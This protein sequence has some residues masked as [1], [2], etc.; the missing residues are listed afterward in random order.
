MIKY[1]SAFSLSILL[2][3]ALIGSAENIARLSVFVLG[4]IVITYLINYARIGFAWP[5][6]LLPSFFLIAVGLSYAVI[7][8]STLRVIFSI[9][10]S[11]LFYFLEI[12][13]GRESHYLQGLF[14]FS[15]FGI[16]T[17]LFALEFYINLNIWLLLLGVI[18]VTYF[19]SL[20]GFA[21]FELK[22]KKNF[23]WVII[24]I[25]FQAALG[26]LLW[27]THFL[28]DASVLFVIFYLL[29][30]FSVS[31]FLGKLTMKKIYMQVALAGI[32]LALILSSAAWKP[33]IT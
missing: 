6:L 24:L 22:T 4:L 12:K 13:L 15:T 7:T 28:I 14:I 1:V 26:L 16:Y 5:H 23:I 32:F 9:I 10:A 33:L 2:F 8:T 29:W 31:A 30:I 17:G 25:V 3:L 11:I 18:L 21:G 27:P 19:F 20:H